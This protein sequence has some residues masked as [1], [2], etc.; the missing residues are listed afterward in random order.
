M[1]TFY[2]AH[3]F[4]DRK[5][6]RKWELKLE[7]KYN[8]NIDNPFYDC[9]RSDIKRLDQMKDNSKEQLEYFKK[10]NTKEQVDLIVDGD[11][12]MIR[13]GDGLI[14]MLNSPSFGTPM[15]IFFAARIL[16]IPVYVITS[17]YT[18]HPWIQKYATRIFRNKTEFEAFVKEEFGLKDGLT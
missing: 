5:M 10:R 3:N 14:T 11:L 2:I 7:A 18:Y 9:D 16:R 8:I 6:I 4:F 17:K 15:E 12:D 1:K 13:K